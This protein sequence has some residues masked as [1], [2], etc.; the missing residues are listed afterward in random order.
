MFLEMTRDEH[1]LLVGL[2]EARIH[3]IGPE[4]RRS[5]DY[6]YHDRLKGEL[7]LLQKLLHHLHES[8]CDVT[9]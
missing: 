1:V 7:E 4:I 6:K 5:R 2:V 9:S 8:E 3:E